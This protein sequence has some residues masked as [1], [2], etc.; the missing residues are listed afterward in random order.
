MIDIPK[1]KKIKAVDPVEFD[2]VQ[3]DLGKKHGL[4]LK[5]KNHRGLP[6]NRT[7]VIMSAL[8][9]LEVRFKP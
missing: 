2:L 4:N 9:P 7:K 5:H 8:G 3:M 1:N 6:L